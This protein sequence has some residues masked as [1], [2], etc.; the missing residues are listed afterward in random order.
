MKKSISERHKE[1]ENI[2]RIYLMRRGYTICRVDGRHFSTETKGLKKPFDEGFIEDMNTTAKALCHGIQGAK[3]AF[4]QSDEISI[5]ICDYDTLDTDAW[6]QNNIQKMCSISASIAT[7]TF[8]QERI[9]RIISEKT[10][11]TKWEDVNSDVFLQHIEQCIYLGGKHEF[12]SRIWQVPS[13]QEVINAFIFRQQDCT[14]NSIQMAASSFYSQKQMHGKNTN[15]LQD[16]LMEK[17]VNW[18]NYPIGQKRGRV[19][20][21]ENYEM[22]DGIKPVTRSR[23]TVVDP[24]VFSQQKDF[25]EMLIPNNE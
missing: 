20:M 12:D 8:N 14:R 25:L 9:K 24:P 23:W 18:N 19:I 2:T 22:K 6:F 5:F 4:V 16:M 15:I 10:S 11:N 21:K 17:G 1:Y 7:K 13:K 3:F